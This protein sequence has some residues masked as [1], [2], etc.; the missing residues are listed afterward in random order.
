MLVTYYLICVSALNSNG[1]T[2]A[3]AMKGAVR[4]SASSFR[5]RVAR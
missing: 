1:L 5:N 2:D 4:S 3:I